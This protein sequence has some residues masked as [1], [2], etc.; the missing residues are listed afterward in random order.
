MGSNPTQSSFFF[1]KRESCPGCISLPCLIVMYV[2]TSVQ[3]LVEEAIKQWNN[4]IEQVLLLGSIMN[5]NC[6]VNSYVY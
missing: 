5:Q 2:H 4:E 3:V 1:E 6:F